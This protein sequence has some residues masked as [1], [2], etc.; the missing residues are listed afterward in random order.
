MKLLSTYFPLEVYVILYKCNDIPIDW[1]ASGLSFMTDI[2]MVTVHTMLS[3][4]DFVAA[5]ESVE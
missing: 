2:A 3:A 1:F 5:V 4:F